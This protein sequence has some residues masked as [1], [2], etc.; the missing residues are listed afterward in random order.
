MILME[1]IK[2]LKKRLPKIKEMEVITPMMGGG[3]DLAY[4]FMGDMVLARKIFERIVFCDPGASKFPQ[5]K[6][7]IKNKVQGKTKI[8]KME[9]LLG[10]VIHASYIV[11]DSSDQLDV[12]NDRGER[13]I[14]SYKKFMS[15]LESLLL[16]Y[17]D[18]IIAMCGIVRRQIQNIEKAHAKLV[19]ERKKRELYTIVTKLE[20]S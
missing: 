19:Q 10:M 14:G 16:E 9:L 1:E 5:I 2:C 12:I 3:I 6:R 11:R 18:I 15:I 7:T 13:F 4:E 8:I 17:N 20:L